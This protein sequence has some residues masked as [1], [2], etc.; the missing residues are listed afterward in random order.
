VKLCEAMHDLA[1]GGRANWV[2]AIGVHRIQ[3]EVWGSKR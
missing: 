3:E 1:K 2:D